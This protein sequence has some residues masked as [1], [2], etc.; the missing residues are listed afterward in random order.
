MISE[1]ADGQDPRLVDGLVDVFMKAQDSV[2]DGVG[3]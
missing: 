3:E 2:A 1:A